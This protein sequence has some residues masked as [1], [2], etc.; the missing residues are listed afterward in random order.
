M[1]KRAWTGKPGQP[2]RAPED[3]QLQ[4]AL[5]QMAAARG[6]VAVRKTAGVVGVWADKDYE[7]YALRFLDGPLPMG[8]ANDRD[9]D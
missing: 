9:A 1:A 4:T 6:G 7:D 3:V 2:T 8:E 5:G